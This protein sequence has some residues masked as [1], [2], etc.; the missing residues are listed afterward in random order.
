[1]K[2]STLPLFLLA[3]FFTVSGC[4]K[5][6]GSGGSGGSGGGSNT[7][8]VI[9]ITTPVAGTIATNGST[10]TVSGDLTDVDG[11]SQ[12]K[13]ELRNKT[14]GS[15]YFQQ[16]SGTGGV[17]FYRFLWSWTVSGITSLTTAT[18]KITCTDR[19]NNSVTKEIDI[20]LDN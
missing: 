14:T 18:L 12:G 7:P 5:D 4:S 11:L 9:N 2:L 8:G 20:Q 19:N 13:V 15:V 16:I 6:S 1:M 3:A 17:T 10:L